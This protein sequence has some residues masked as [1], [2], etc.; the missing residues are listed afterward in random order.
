M[1]KKEMDQLTKDCIE[2]RKAGMSYG[3]WKAM[4]PPRK[5]A[6]DQ[7]EEN[8]S[9]KY[10]RVCGTMIPKTSKRL[11]YCSYDCQRKYDYHA[12]RT[13]KYVGG[14]DDGKI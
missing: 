1:A 13:R 14:E 5:K 12:N 6:P 3:K 4:Q 11:V 8:Q 7:E 10:C 9:D 2:A